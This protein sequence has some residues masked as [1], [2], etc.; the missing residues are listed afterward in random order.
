MEYTSQQRT[1]RGLSMFRRGCGAREPRC[2]GAGFNV[3]SYFLSYTLPIYIYTHMLHIYIY[4][5][6]C[7]ILVD[8]TSPDTSICSIR[9]E[10]PRRCRPS[11][12]RGAFQKEGGGGGVGEG[13]GQPG[14][15]LRGVGC[16]VEGL[17]V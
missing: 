5:Y 14:G 4:I 6:A 16:R 9:K 12:M 7:Y 2:S 1:F 8:D 11:Q 15:G 13:G 3:L 17:G 10:R